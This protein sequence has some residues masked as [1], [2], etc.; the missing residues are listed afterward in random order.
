M[1]RVLTVLLTAV[2]LCTWPV[3]AGAAPDAQ[4]PLTADDFWIRD[5][6]VLLHDDL[7]YMYGTCQTNVP[8][9]G[10]YIS[11]DLVHWAGPYS[12]FTATPDFDGAGDY[13]APECYV[14]GGAFYLFATYRSRST[15][16]RGVSV[17]RASS[18]MGPFEEIS[19]GHITP[20][21][22][23]C[24]DGT[25]YIDPYGNPS[26]VYVREWTGTDDRCGR[27]DTAF[28]SRD[29]SHFVS[30][31]KE[32]FHAREPRWKPHN[33]TDGPFMYTSRTGKLLMLWS[34]GSAAKGYCVAL[35]SAD[36]VTGLWRQ[37]RARLYVKE[38]GRHPFDG[39]HGMLFT[40][41]SGQLTLSIHSPNDGEVGP[42]RPLFLPVRDLGY[43]LALDEPP[44]LR[45]AFLRALDFFAA[46]FR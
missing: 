34:N 30:A 26:M 44:T 19:D 16:H 3:F 38:S 5:P 20:H 41:K 28:L 6:F 18:P 13:W 43:T 1:R 9:Y 46:F 39:G 36:S 22:Y 33:I 23:D 37:Q 29:L 17:F 7:Y 42:A 2:L 10:C 35:A 12:V 21:E 15:G 14:Y 27:M 8:G 32:L 40:D 11:P 25:L 31:P 24:I 45:T 4:Y